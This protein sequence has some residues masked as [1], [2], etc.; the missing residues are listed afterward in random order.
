VIDFR[1]HIVSLISVFLALA[2]GIALGAGPLKETIGDTLTG[3][4][5]Q[6]RAEK[7]TLRT[8]LDESSGDLADT[9]AYVDA[10]APQLLAGAL[11][12]RRI[13]VVALGAVDDE[14]SKALDERLAQ[15][16]ATVT[17]HVTLTDSWT[18]PDVAS[19]R[20]A[21]VGNILTLLDPVPDESEGAQT[22]L[23]YALVE[24]LT[25]A[26]PA[27][28][29]ALTLDASSMLE[30]LSGGDSPLVTLQDPVETPADAIV[31]LAPPE[32]EDTGD[33]SPTAAADSQELLDA[34]LGVLGA[35]QKLT[36][37]AVLADGPLVD[38]SLTKAILADDELASTLTTVSESADVP[39]QVSVPLALA[40]RIGGVNGH[41]G[42]GDG[43]TVMPEPVTLAP[44]DRTPQTALTPPAS[45]TQG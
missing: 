1:Y 11:T 30:V 7:D 9:T 32:A 40:A 38:G 19:Y 22:D 23:S 21:L 5:E 31:V 12:D 2:V 18:D 37:G 44:V 45:E 13:A 25:G 6:L 17:A 34:R 36:E 16:G 8:Q 24:G 4:V 20:Q 43:L 15:A 42:F 35:A 33:A 41:Y 28:P 27:S 29:D 3:Q 39:G 10:A 26:D 14:R